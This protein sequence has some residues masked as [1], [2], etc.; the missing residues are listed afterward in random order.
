M[1][2]EEMR[3]L[4]PKQLEV[5]ILGWRAELFKERVTANRNKKAAKPHLFPKIKR[6][7]AQAYTLIKQMNSAGG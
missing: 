2:L 5:Q 7:I 1:K 4:D 6:Q 3:G